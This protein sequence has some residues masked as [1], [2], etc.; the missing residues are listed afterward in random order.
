MS[1]MVGKLVAGDTLDFLD[2]VPGYEAT[3]GWTLKYRLA[4]RFTTPV[5]VPFDL[6]AVPE[7]ADYRVQ[8]TPLETGSWLPGQYTWARWVEKPGAR[9]SLG[10]GELSVTPDPATLAAGADLRSPTRKALD[11]ALAAQRSFVATRGA[12]AEYQIGERR[13]KFSSSADFIGLI[14]QLRIDLAREVRAEALAAGMPDP[15]KVY[16]RSRRG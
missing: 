6:T 15:R 3:A 11:D 10:T 4:P 2:V 8:A 5:Q 14:N 12:V 7:G 13:M 16:V 1:N 9:Q